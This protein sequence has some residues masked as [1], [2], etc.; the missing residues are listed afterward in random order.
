MY[1]LK[2]LLLPVALAACFVFAPAVTPFAA[3]T[4]HAAAITKVAPKPAA[5]PVFNGRTLYDAAL[6]A[7]LENHLR[8][9]DPAKNAA[10]NKEWRNKFSAKQL[11]TEEGAD[12]AIRQMLAALKQRHDGYFDVSEAKEFNAEVKGT[13]E[14]VGVGIAFQ[15]VIKIDV[16]PAKAVFDGD[17]VV[18]IVGDTEF[19]GPADG[20]LFPGDRII[21]VDSKDI[22]FESLDLVISRIGTHPQGDTVN[23]TVLRHGKQLTVGVK[24]DVIKKRAVK[25]VDLGDGITLIRVKDFL[26]EKVEEEFVAALEQAVKGKGIIIDLRGNPGG[27][28]EKSLRMASRFLPD[29]TILVTRER[30]G[31]V[32]VE[33]SIGVFRDIW[34]DATRDNRDATKQNV[35]MSGRPK[36]IVPATMPVKVLVDGGSA[37]ASEIFTGALQANRRAAVL[38]HESS[39]GKNV[40]QLVVPLPFGREIHITTFEFLPGGVEMPSVGLMPDKE[41]HDDPNTTEDEEVTAAVQDIKQDLAAAERNAAWKKDVEKQRKENP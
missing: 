31:R 13:G 34:V 30:N 12:D 10:F 41:V 4:I 33:K 23:F 29:G 6:K 19:G 25:S 38:G 24:R 22:E 35:K 32:V 15:M 39:F 9:Q 11:S 21:A 17:R 16:D 14:R 20:I 8:L 18:L 2:K 1:G 40:G 27:E 5:K 3:N 37:S 7:V 28:L 36:M 26:W